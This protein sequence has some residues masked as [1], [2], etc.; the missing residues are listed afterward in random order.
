MQKISE[1]DILSIRSLSELPRGFV[2]GERDSGLCL[3]AHMEKTAVCFIFVSSS[4]N[5]DRSLVWSDSSGD[6][7]PADQHKL[8]LAYS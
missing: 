2:F 3:G 5:C 1:K 6:N 4:E 8:F 7:G